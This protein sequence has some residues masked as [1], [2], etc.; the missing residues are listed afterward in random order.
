[1][2]RRFFITLIALGSCVAAVAQHYRVSYVRDSNPWLSTG[3]AAALTLLNVQN[4]SEA[5]LAFKTE[6]AERSDINTPQSAKNFCADVESFCRIMP[7]I[8]GYGRISYKN[9][10]QHLIA[11]SAFINTLNMPF[12]IVEDSIANEGDAHKDAYDIVGALGYDVCT[13]F[14]VGA[15]VEFT[16]ADYAKYKDLRH[17]NSLT[18]ITA[19]VGVFSPLAPFLQ[20]GGNVFYRRT[21]EGVTF[22]LYGSEDKVYRSLIDY[23]IFSGKVETFGENGYTEKNTDQPFFS[24]QKGFSIQLGTGTCDNALSLVNEFGYRHRSGYYGRDTE[25]SIVHNRHAGNIYEARSTVVCRKRSGMHQLLFALAIENLQNDASTYLM[26][27]DD[28]T[29]AHYYQYFTPVKMSNKLW[30]NYSLGYRGYIGIRDNIP[31]WTIEGKAEYRSREQ[32]VY[33]YPYSRHQFLEART[34]SASLLRNFSIDKAMLSVYAAMAYRWGEG[35]IY[36]TNVLNTSASVKLHEPETMQYYL[37]C[38]YDDFVAAQCTANIAARFALPIPSAKLTAY[39]Q[40]EGF[41]GR[42]RHS[43]GFSLGAYF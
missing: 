15:K 34:L 28:K 13:R 25:Y 17:K 11:G 8:A 10:A 20:I 37:Q 7:R 36:S 43:I 32:T 22:C 27:Q 29:S 42:K 4:A 5:Q 1:M 16:A 14:A 40:A 12:D 39:V 33:Y 18:D 19:T 26:L 9:I 35:D 30:Q 3:N 41:S 6:D 31:A 24:E 38:D 2:D 21:I 23:G